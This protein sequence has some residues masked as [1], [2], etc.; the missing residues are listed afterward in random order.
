VLFGAPVTE[1]RLEIGF[2]SGEH[3]LSQAEENPAV[4]FLGVEPFVN[5]M[6]KAL[7]VI[8]A[9]SLS[10][11]RLHLGDA[12]DVLGWLAPASLAAIDL[13][14][15]DPWPKRR[16]WKRRFVQPSSVT[17]MARA[18]RPGGE[19]RF[20]TDVG[21]YA[22]WTLGHLLRAPD[23]EWTAECADHWRLPWRG[24]AGTR[25][26]AKA[27]HAGR[28]CWYL[29]FKKRAAAQSGALIP[30]LSGGASAAPAK[31]A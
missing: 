19:L 22:A 8:A 6:A 9:R 10:N 12:N 16:H 21:D 27:R 4:G 13:L 17:A 28:R 3:L 23:L 15:P 26:E 5:G 31:I 30:R 1:L 20:A 14:Y 2:G 11:V 25:Y 29:T 7:S 24:F 18:L